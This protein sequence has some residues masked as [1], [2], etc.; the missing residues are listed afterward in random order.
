[1]SRGRATTMRLSMALFLIGSS[2][3]LAGCTAGPDAYTAS[4]TYAGSNGY[5]YDAGGYA[6]GVPGSAYVAPP[7]GYEYGGPASYGAPVYVGGG[8]DDW[9]RRAWQNN[10]EAQRRQQEQQNAAVHHQQVQQNQATYQR[11]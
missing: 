5:G 9:R 11:Q 3:G 7:P 4:P 8:D 6:A 2:V 10:A 1:M